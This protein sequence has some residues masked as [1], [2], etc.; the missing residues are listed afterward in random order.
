LSDIYTIS[1]NLAGLPAMSVPCGFTSDKQGD[2]P[3]G[4]QLI[5]NYFEEDKLLNFAHQYQL[6]TEWH[7][8][9]PPG[10]IE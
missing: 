1:I 10:F 6:D 7:K 9:S 8:K 3:V 2:L 4:M 5:G